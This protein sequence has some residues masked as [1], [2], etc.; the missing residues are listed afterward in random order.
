M[1][2][3]NTKGELVVAKRIE[4][5]TAIYPKIHGKY[6]YWDENRGKLHTSWNRPQD[7]ELGVVFVVSIDQPTDEDGQAN[8]EN[9]AQGRG[10]EPSLGLLRF[11]LCHGIAKPSSG[12]KGEEK[13]QADRSIQIGAAKVLQ[14]VEEHFVSRC[15]RVETADTR[16]T[17]DLANT[18]IE[19]ASGHKRANSRERYKVDNEAEA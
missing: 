18:N 13:R 3:P 9:S 15:A 16:Q 11:S 10:E 4:F 14:E 7:L 2:E 1:F 5:Q 17:W 12:I 8:D 19:R 6:Q